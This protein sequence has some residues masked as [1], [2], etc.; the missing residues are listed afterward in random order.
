MSASLNLEMRDM[1]IRLYMANTVPPVDVFP[2]VVLMWLSFLHL[3]SK[4]MQKF[5]S[6]EH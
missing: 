6:T 5:K 2:K 4:A 3:F 1:E